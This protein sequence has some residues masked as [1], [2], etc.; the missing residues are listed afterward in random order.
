M[1]DPEHPD[2]SEPSDDYLSPQD[3]RIWAEQEIKDARRALDLRVKD[4]TQMSTAYAN[5]TL[6]PE[7]A[8]EAHSRYYHRWGEAL[9]GATTSE[10]VSDDE[11]LTMVD[12]ARGLLP[13]PRQTEE[14]VRRMISRNK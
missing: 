9:P 5:G 2:R 13:G 3:I 11:I 4:L 12:K 10:F 1:A 14:K 6:T 8:D 7:Q